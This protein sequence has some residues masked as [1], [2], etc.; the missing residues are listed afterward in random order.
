MS[1]ES[2]LKE[3]GHSRLDLAC[4]YIDQ[5]NDEDAFRAFVESELKR[6][7]ELRAAKYQI[8]NGTAYSVR[9]SKKV[10]DILESARHMRVRLSITFGTIKE[11]GSVVSWGPPERG[12][13]TR[14]TG[15][16]M[17]PCLIKTSR[18]AFGDTITDHAIIKIAESNGGRILYGKTN[19]NL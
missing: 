12:Y 14:T 3:A 4:K 17:V 9:T 10:I 11:D 8:V 19:G 5:L 16:F 1:A 7:T 15:M 18:S 2:I 13:V 6:E